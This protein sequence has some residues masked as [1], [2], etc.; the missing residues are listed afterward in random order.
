MLRLSLAPRI[1]QGASAMAMAGGGGGPCV[2]ILLV[3]VRIAIDGVYEQAKLAGS[4]RVYWFTFNTNHTAM[5]LYD[6]VAEKTGI[7]VYRK[8]I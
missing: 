6:K 2:C 1:W 8:L 5:Q 3:E 4:P 7:V